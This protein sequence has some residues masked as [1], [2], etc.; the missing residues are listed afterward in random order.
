M[1]NQTF[2]ITIPVKLVAPETISIVF[3]EPEPNIAY[4]YALKFD[5][6]TLLA[7]IRIKKWAAAGEKF[8]KIVKFG[9]AP[10]IVRDLLIIKSLFLLSAP[11]KPASTYI[12]SPALAEE[13]AL[14]KVAKGLDTVPAAASLPLADPT[15]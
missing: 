3:A 2:F 15:V 5:K 8:S 12:K 7:V 14:S 13:I 10:V 4:L 1:S 6:T 11:Y 9:P